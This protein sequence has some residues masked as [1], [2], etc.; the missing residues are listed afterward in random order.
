M[1]AKTPRK[2]AGCGLNWTRPLDSE[3]YPPSPLNRPPTSG[4]IQVYTIIVMVEDSR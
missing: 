4:K 1:D 3:L 2:S